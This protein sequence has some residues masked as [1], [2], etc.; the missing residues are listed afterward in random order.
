VRHE[1]RNSLSATYL[2]LNEFS[3]CANDVHPDNR[4]VGNL[5]ETKA[6]K[7]RGSPRLN[8]FEARSFLS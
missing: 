2:F 7:C 3:Y 8:R 5:L 1:T 6:G 4:V